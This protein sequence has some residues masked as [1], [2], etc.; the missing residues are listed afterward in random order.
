M[1]PSRQPLPSFPCAR[2]YMYP[3]TRPAPSCSSGRVLSA[4]TRAWPGPGVPRSHRTI[5]Y[6]GPMSRANSRC[7]SASLRKGRP[8]RQT[9]P[10]RGA[11]AASSARI[12]DAPKPGYRLTRTV[13]WSCRFRGSGAPRNAGSPIRRPG[14]RRASRR[15]PAASSP[16]V[17]AEFDDAGGR[18][19]VQAAARLHRLGAV[20]VHGRL[21]IVRDCPGGSGR[22]PGGPQDVQ[23]RRAADGLRAHIPV[24]SR[25]H[26]LV[27]EVQR[28]QRLLNGEPERRL[29]LAVPVGQQDAAVAMIA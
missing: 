4:R 26:R 29:P 9:R 10:V 17:G 23:R 28:V 11:F 25:Q 5:R 22:P 14:R 27:G 7:P 12:A 21:G 13:P 1:S 8:L 3:R 2:A 16:G 19:A 18:V 6:L 24:E 15:R 20:G